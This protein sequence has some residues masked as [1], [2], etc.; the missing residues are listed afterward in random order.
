MAG[1]DRAGAVERRGQQPRPLRLGGQ[2]VAAPVADDRLVPYCPVCHR[3]F[4][5]G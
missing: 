5:P 3:S 2:D 1:G 4:R